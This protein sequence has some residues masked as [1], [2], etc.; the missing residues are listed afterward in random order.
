M[1]DDRTFGFGYFENREPYADFERAGRAVLDAVRGSDDL[2]DRP[3]RD[4][5][6][7]FSVLPWIRFTSFAHARRCPVT[8]SIPR[9]VFGARHPTS[10]GGH[11]MPISI[12]V[13]HALV[14]GVH[15]ADF[16]RRFEERL[17]AAAELLRG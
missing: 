15:V 10:D 17:A 13:H 6:V 4:D 3:E 8:E 14:D 12:E 1:R 9:I 7:Y 11:R 16:L 2:A 5:V